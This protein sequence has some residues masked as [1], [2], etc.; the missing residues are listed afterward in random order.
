VTSAARHATIHDFHGFPEALHRLEYPAPG[1]PEM[2]GRIVALLNAAGLPA[3]PE[4]ERGLDHGAW[5]PL[6][7]AWPEADIPVVQVSIQSS[8]G[9]ARQFAIGRA[10]R[11]LAGEGWLVVA[12][13]ASVHNL[14][15]LRW[16]RDGAPAAWARAFQDWLIDAVERGDETALADYRARAP[17]AREAHPTDEHLQPL[18]VAAGA[19]GQG[20]KGTCL[21]RDY[22]HGSLGMASFVFEPSVG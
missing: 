11:P 12:S 1:A 10:L 15:A 13:G 2:A 8:H 6:K 5:V 21:H 16:T 4:A 19:A 17:H 9:A 3:R 22:S 18:F 20:W 14:S 7:L